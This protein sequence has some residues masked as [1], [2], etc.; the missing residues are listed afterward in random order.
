M[1]DNDRTC[2]TC[3]LCHRHD[4]RNPGLD[5]YM[6]LANKVLAATL[7]LGVGICTD[8]PSQPFLV[9]LDGPMPCGGESWE[10]RPQGGIN[11]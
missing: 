9:D 1:S 11:W 3:G 7:R 2:A 10:P 8:E 6:E 4:E 5:P